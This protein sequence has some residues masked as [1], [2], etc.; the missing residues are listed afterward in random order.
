MSFEKPVWRYYPPETVWSPSV[1]E[2][3]AE[4][5]T[6]R[7]DPLVR[8]REVA[9]RMKLASDAAAWLARALP[10]AYAS[11]S[12][13]L[14]D[15]D[16]D[17]SASLARLFGEELPDGA[18]T[19][20]MYSRLLDALLGS[21]QTQAAL[22]EFAL[23]YQVS[24]VQQMDLL[25]AVSAV[26]EAFA[27]SNSFPAQHLLA[28]P[29]LK[30]DAWMWASLAEMLDPAGS[31]HQAGTPAPEAKTALSEDAPPDL[32]APA[33]DAFLP[34]ETPLSQLVDLSRLEVT[35]EKEPEPLEDGYRGFDADTSVVDEPEPPGQDDVEQPEFEMDPEPDA[36]LD[37]AEYEEWLDRLED[38]ADQYASHWAMLS[39]SGSIL[40]ENPLNVL[41]RLSRAMDEMHSGVRRLML[42]YLTWPANRIIA[43][44]ATLETAW[45]LKDK[46]RLAL[47]KGAFGIFI[48]A[49]LIQETT[50][51]NF[52]LARMLTRLTAPLEQA[53]NSASRLTNLP[54]EALSEID[55]VLSTAS[56]SR[57]AGKMAGRVPRDGVEDL[58]RKLQSVPKAISSLSRMLS[59]ARA[60][61]INRLAGAQASMFQLIDRRLMQGASQA[62]ALDALRT[63]QELK[64]IFSAIVRY[65]KNQLAGSAETQGQPVQT[66]R[67]AEDPPRLVMEPGPE[68]W[69]SGEANDSSR[70]DNPRPDQNLAV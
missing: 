61:L 62:D 18:V 66:A 55:S 4:T 30:A 50:R 2:P 67:V 25:R 3:G 24:P 6:G 37:P 32:D 15:S 35:F 39:G 40:D 63:F 43:I 49:R 19:A 57:V 69:N 13:R 9:R 44:L 5:R 8:R 45:R 34:Q 16:P 29:Y 17:L 22:E 10:E 1:R 14:P 54:Y 68:R 70:T 48:L 12:V 20:A 58:A 41:F 47:A 65:Q 26:E 53:L 51:L 7:A 52:F 56:R 38:A 23:P 27:A 31:A 42:E 33:E 28:L 60:A 36:D 21:V 11:V 64:S 59:S 46:D